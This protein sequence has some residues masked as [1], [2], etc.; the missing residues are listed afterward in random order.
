V[1]RQFNAPSISASARRNSLVLRVNAWRVRF[2]VVLPQSGDLLLR[3]KHLLFL[4]EFER[5]LIRAKKR[6]RKRAKGEALMVWSAPPSCVR[7]R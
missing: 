4:A 1:T 3:A 5:E 7:R 6:G 2:L